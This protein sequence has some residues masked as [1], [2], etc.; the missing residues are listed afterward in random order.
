MDQWV[1]LSV[2]FVHSQI[3]SVFE[4]F[5]RSWPRPMLIQMPFFYTYD[6]IFC[7]TGMDKYKSL[8]KS[9]LHSKLLL[10]SSLL[11][12]SWTLAPQAQFFSSF[13]TCF[14]LPSHRRFG[15]VIPDSCHHTIAITPSPSTTTSPWSRHHRSIAKAPTARYQTK[16]PRFLC[17]RSANVRKISEGRKRRCSPLWQRQPV[18]HLAEARTRIACHILQRLKT[19]PEVRGGGEE[20]EGSGAKGWKVE[21]RKGERNVFRVFWA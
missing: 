8:T 9:S 15:S 6:V 17:A 10:L 11:T 16:L 1:W 12:L 13:C 21:G 4:I 14:L 20:D 3:G 19:M 2:S 7:I 5:F 18:P